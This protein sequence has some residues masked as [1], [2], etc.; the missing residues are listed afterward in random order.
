MNIPKLTCPNCHGA[1]VG[2]SIL[3]NLETQEV[4]GYIGYCKSLRCR[5]RKV[6]YDVNFKA[7]GVTKFSS[8]QKK[9]EFLYNY[10]RDKRRN[11]NW[12]YRKKT[13]KVYYKLKEEF[14]GNK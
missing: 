14:D 3:Q 6:T 4:Y 13:S 1:I 8:L 11:A 9:K 2:I 7:I 12:K 10:L 5:V